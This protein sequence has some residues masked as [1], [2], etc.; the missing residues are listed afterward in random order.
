M[1]YDDGIRMITGRPARSAAMPVLFLLRGYTLFRQI[2]TKKYQ[3]QRFGGLVS[4]HFKTDRG[5]IW[6]EGTDL[7]SYPALNFVEITGRICP[8]REN[9]YQKIE[10]FAFFSYLSRQVYT[11]NVTIVLMRMVGFENPSTK[12]IF[13]KIA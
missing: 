8:L 3:F 11:H 12:Q 10:I 6:R 1:N 2:Y 13:V 9:F 7:I 5:E 4:P